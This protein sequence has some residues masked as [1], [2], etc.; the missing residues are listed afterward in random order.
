MRTP[1]ANDLMSRT[2]AIL[3][4]LGILT[5]GGLVH[6]FW[7]ERW[8]ASSDLEEAAS[9]VDRV[10]LAA[11]DWQAQSVASDPAIFLQAGARG[12]WTRCYVNAKTKTT[13]F[14]ILMCGRSG[15]MAVHTPEVCYRGA[16]YELGGRPDAW[17]VNSASG[18]ELGTFWTARFLK[19]TGVTSDLRL[20]WGW[21]TGGLW[22]AS[23]NP[24]WQFGGEPFLNKLY[25]SHDAPVR[26]TN[27]AAAVED[28]LRQFLP[29]LHETLVERG[30]C[31]EGEGSPSAPR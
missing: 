2:A 6:G 15:R 26:G 14:V 12:Y 20:H 23:A 31:C 19:R 30:S 13:L 4:A 16:G 1:G 11:G 17:T 8:S 24:R 21:S 7:S 5:A 29:E 28:F 9:R 18:Q 22:Q 10:P 27:S 3:M 25:V